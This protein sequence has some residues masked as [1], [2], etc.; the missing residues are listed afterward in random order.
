MVGEIATVNVICLVAGHK[1]L[2]DV[3][4]ENDAP[5]RWTCKRCG[6]HTHSEPS[7]TTWFGAGAG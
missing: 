7:D 1:Y 2:R 5:P 3:K 4:E 6:S